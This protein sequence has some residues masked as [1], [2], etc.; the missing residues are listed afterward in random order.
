MSWSFIYY[1]HG[2]YRVRIS[3]MFLQCMCLQSIFGVVVST[4]ACGFNTPD[5]QCL[6]C[7]I[8]SIYRLSTLDT[9]QR[10]LGVGRDIISAIKHVP[11]LWP[12]A[13][14][15]QHC[16]CCPFLALS[17][18]V[19]LQIVS[20][21]VWLINSSASSTPPL[22]CGAV[23]YSFHAWGVTLYTLRWRWPRECGRLYPSLIMLNADR[24]ANFL[25]CGLSK[26][27]DIR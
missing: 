9:M 11:C 26:K 19:G 25:S 12:I 16:S 21:L 3:G 18:V 13:A 4:E 6:E 24:I 7:Y 2:I 23:L 8:H 10:S 1:F 5:N 22:H 17:L 14:N 27:C 15:S 20:F